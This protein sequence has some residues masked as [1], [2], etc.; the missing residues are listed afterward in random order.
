MATCYN[1]SPWDGILEYQNLNLY[2]CFDPA[3]A[4]IAV[5]V[6]FSIGLNPIFL[7][8][9]EPDESSE[10]NVFSIDSEPYELTYGE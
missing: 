8:T 3:V 9:G 10:T 2:F 5:G 4:A 6:T 1:F 7:P